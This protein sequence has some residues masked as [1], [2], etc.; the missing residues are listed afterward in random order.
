MKSRPTR[1]LNNLYDADVVC[2]ACFCQLELFEIHRIQTVKDE[3]SN[4]IR[5]QLYYHAKS[6]EHLSSCLAH[7]EVCA[8]LLS[9]G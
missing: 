9:K 2:D 6:V 5:C 4:M 1:T 7:F 8:S 3:M